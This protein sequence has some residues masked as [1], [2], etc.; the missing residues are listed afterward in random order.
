MA[1]LFR[2]SWHDVLPR[3]L[4]RVSEPCDGGY[5]EI[6]FSSFDPSHGAD[7]D[8]G[9]LCQP[10]LGHAQRGADAPNIVPQLFELR[11]YFAFGHATLVATF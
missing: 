11:G 3:A 9:Q 2:F 4:Q 1:R 10:F 7:V 5:E 8:V 6:H